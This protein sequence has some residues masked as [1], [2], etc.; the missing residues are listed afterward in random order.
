MAEHSTLR[1]G[2]NKPISKVEC[3][4]AIKWLERLFIK[5]TGLCE[6]AKGSIGSDTCPV[7]EG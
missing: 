5:N 1:I 6:P 3:S 7:L 4:V 2:I